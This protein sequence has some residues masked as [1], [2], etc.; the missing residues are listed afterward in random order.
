MDFKVAGT[1]DGITACQMDIKIRG[2]S[3]E[4]MRTLWSRRAKAVCTS[5]ARWRNASRAPACGP[6]AVRTAA[7]H[8]QDPDRHDRCG[9]RTGRK[10]HPQD[11]GGQRAEIN[12]EDDGS[13]VIAATSKEAAD[14]AI[15]A[16]SRITEVPG[17]REDLHCH[18]EE[19]HGLRRVRRIPAGQGRSRPCVAARRQARRQSCRC[20]ARWAMCSM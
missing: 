20:R 13:V 2:I 4:I 1:K 16:I 5:S 18:G 10:E 12:I 11:R 15:N 17:G 19:D 8:P 14:K 7:D 9:D 6:L 3:L